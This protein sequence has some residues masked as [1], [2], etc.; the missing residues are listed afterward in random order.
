MKLYYA[1]GAC[2]LGPHIALR[3]AGLDF[4]LERVDLLAKQTAAGGDYQKINPK[5]QV[6]ALLLD[7][8]SL[9]TENAAV[10]QYI[11]DRGGDLI[12]PAGSMERYR[13][14]EWLSFIGA[15]LHK[16]FGPLFRGMQGEARQAF[17]D[18]LNA[19][20]GY[21]E[22]VLAERDHLLGS[23]SVA[24][25][26]AFAVLRWTKD[27]NIPLDATPNVAAYLKRIAERPMVRE[28]MR[29]EGLKD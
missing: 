15:E 24:D 9:L 10:L 7:D 16:N 11:G 2:S 5:G 18:I 1:P 27:V 17:V 21:I 29:A 8:G 22:T 25:C 23:F 20:I 13:A 19:K 26:Y 4:E 14:Q 3:E 12:P 6:S 28:A